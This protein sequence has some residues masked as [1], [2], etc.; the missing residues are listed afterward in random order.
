ML[1]PLTN[2][3][4]ELLKCNT[5]WIGDTGATIH[6]TLS[7]LNVI[8]KRVTTSSMNGM[9]VGSI[10]A[11]LQMKL[12]CI[13]VNKNDKEASPV[14]L[15]KVALL[16]SSNYNLCSVSKLLNRGRKMH[17]N[18]SKVVTTNG[19]KVLTSDIVIKTTK[20][21]LFCAKF[22]RRG[23]AIS[24]ANTELAKTMNINSAHRLLGCANKEA[25][26]EMASRLG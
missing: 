6:S 19:S 2:H 13:A 15:G 4:L 10:K 20:G 23:T 14:L 8:N 1:L 7:A 11:S 17:G 3:G 18:A 16:E 12:E 22:K 21:A 9:S 5:I 25:T 24:G 26:Q